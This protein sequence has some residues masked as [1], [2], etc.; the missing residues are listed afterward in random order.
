MR[1]AALVVFGRRPNCF[2]LTEKNLNQF[3]HDVRKYRLVNTI[4]ASFNTVIGEM[5]GM[6]Q[7]K[8]IRIAN[9]LDFLLT[10]GMAKIAAMREY[11]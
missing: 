7:R 1:I 9:E 10:T 5:T 3:G 4:M 6:S 11:S 2:E 8:K